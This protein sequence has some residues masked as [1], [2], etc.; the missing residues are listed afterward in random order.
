MIISLEGKLTESTAL[1]IVVEAQGI[2]YEVHVPLCTVEQLPPV[3]H[4]VR[5][6]TYAVYREDAQN[7]YGFM[8]REE[9]NFFKL[10]VEKVSGVGPKV[11]LGLFSKLSLSSLY[12]ALASGD[13]TLLSKCPGIGKKTAERLVVELKDK[14]APVLN[15]V[16]GP[17]FESMGQSARNSTSQEQDAIAALLALGYKASEA[18]RSVRLALSKLGSEAT[19]ESLIKYA[20][21]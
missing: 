7:L 19:T 13:V 20:L 14:V 5:L 1:T 4:N 9:R 18:D 11:A 17:L 3:G 10:I 21:N 16:R 6:H 15:A 8:S 2:G 12:N